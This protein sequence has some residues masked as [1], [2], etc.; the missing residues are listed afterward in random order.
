[1]TR[2]SS[3]AI[4]ILR[5]CS[6]GACGV[7]AFIAIT[8]WSR[9][10]GFFPAALGLS[11]GI[12]TI[13]HAPSKW[14][15]LSDSRWSFVYTTSVHREDPFRKSDM[16]FRISGELRFASADEIQRLAPL[17]FYGAWLAQ[18]EGAY[19][20]SWRGQYKRIKCTPIDRSGSVRVVAGFLPPGLGEGDGLG[21]YFGTSPLLNWLEAGRE[22][23]LRRGSVDI[24]NPNWE[25][26]AGES[27]VMEE[28]HC[29]G[30]EGG[31]SG[32]TDWPIDS[33]QHAFLLTGGPQAWRSP[34]FFAPESVNATL[35]L[36]CIEVRSTA[37]PCKRWNCDAAGLRLIADDHLE[38]PQESLNDC[39]RQVCV[40]GE[41]TGL[42]DDSEAPVQVSSS[43]CL[44]QICYEG[45]PM[46]VFADDEVPSQDAPDDCWRHVCSEGYR[47][48][49]Y[50][51]SEIPKQRSPTDCLREICRRGQVRQIAD[52]TEPGCR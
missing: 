47:D 4:R 12:G 32:N 35:T 18:G 42:P 8:G 9:G 39:S 5:L 30:A 43:D 19:T 38:L 13:G 10:A 41:P 52:D 22:D 34:H 11:G 29:G 46:D 2:H 40:E 16:S 45:E 36:A 51:D 49:E 1:M 33:G 28:Y 48:L 15:H 14:L 21:L 20:Y 17:D 44:R 3:S 37:P 27:Y 23:A 7:A 25:R 24:L 26:S 6:V 31:A 50:D